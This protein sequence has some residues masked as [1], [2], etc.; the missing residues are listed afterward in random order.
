MNKSQAKS[1]QYSWHDNIE[2][3]GI[4]NDIPEDNLEK[5]VI[6]ICHDSD[7]EIE[8]KDIERCHRLPVSGYSRDSNKRVIVKFIN[9]KHPEAMLRN[10]KSISNKDFSHLNVHGKVFVSV[11]LCPYYRYIW[12]KCKD[13]QRRG[14][15]YQVFCLGGTIAVKVTKRSSARKIFHECD[16]LDLDTD[17]V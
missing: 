5:V 2:L 12:G 13:L 3:S 10:K 14:K 4:P 1:E 9:R 6:D 16:L 11:S 7:V 15:I 8:P 17:D